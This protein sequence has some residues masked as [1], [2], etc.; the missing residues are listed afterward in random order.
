VSGSIH[1]EK[2]LWL[3]MA[4]PDPPNNGQF[5]YSKGLVDAAASAGI[6]LDI[7]ALAR[8]DGHDEPERRDRQ[9]WWVAHDRQRS[10]WESAASDLP[11]V[12]NRA[13]T[14]AMR[15]LLA[16]ALEADDEWDA[17]AF[18][19]L[20][21]GWGVRQVLAHGAARPAAPR[22]IY[23]AHNHETSLAQRVVEIHPH[24]L[25]RQVNRVDAV[26]VRWLERL[27]ASHAD[28]ITA[29]SPEDCALFRAEY[30]HARVDCLPPVFLGTP[31]AARRIGP[32]VPRRAVIL[33][34][35]DWLPKRVNL[36]E[37][38]HVADP[39]F[40]AAGV[41]LQ[42]VGAAEQGFLDALRQTTR[43]TTFTGPVA[44]TGPYLADARIG[45]AAERVGGG[46]KLK[47]LDYVFH[48]VPLAALAGTIPGMPVRDGHS[49]LICPD[50]A[51]LAR[52]I[53]GVIDDLD[54]LNRMQTLAYKACAGV[55]V[56]ANAAR[57][58]RRAAAAGDRASPRPPILA[59]TAVT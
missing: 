59:A 54:T 31:V 45:I 57:I 2:W 38:L 19:S 18:D 23:V 39:L 13:N 3:T 49:A 21:A 46:F 15:R 24:P 5:L 17:I 47:T 30:P 36:I 33:G 9:R 12:A 22:L 7:I 43:A 56:L 50:A 6:D 44:D 42:V 34:S 40:A 10:R 48:R 28:V 20:A 58:L 4:V 55:F 32:H 11:H 25:K 29:N 1:P 51:L 8:G 27:L 26:K 41:E 52:R 35:Y 16:Q 53:I 14:P 37:F